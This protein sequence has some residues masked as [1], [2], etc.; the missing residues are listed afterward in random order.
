MKEN[1]NNFPYYLNAI[2]KMGWEFD[3]LQAFS[4]AGDIRPPYPYQWQATTKLLV[5]EDDVCE[6]IG[7]SPL[8]AVRNLYK[9][10][11]ASYDYDPEELLSAP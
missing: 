1:N 9:N 8:E 3:K 11:K 4:T 6:G 2:R 5:G 10:V 7:G